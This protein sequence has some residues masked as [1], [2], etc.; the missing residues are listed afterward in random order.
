MTEPRI[1]R[2]HPPM[3]EDGPFTPDEVW[4]EM[5]SRPEFAW[6]RRHEETI[7]A[8]AGRDLGQAPLD[9]IAQVWAAVED[10]D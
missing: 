7:A 4:D 3:P 8:N 10:L 5:M 9:P 1:V 6:E 2:S